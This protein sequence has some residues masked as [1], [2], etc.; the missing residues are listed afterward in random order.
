MIARDKNQITLI[1]SGNTSIGVQAYA[2]LEVS[3]KRHLAIDISKSKLG[4]TIWVEIAEA[5]GVKVGDLLDKKVIGMED[6]S[7][8]FG[9]H[10][11][12]KIIQK[13]DRVLEKPIVIMGDQ[14]VQ[15]KDP[16]DILE[17][18][19]VDSAGLNQSPMP[20]GSNDIQRTTEG[21]TFIDKKD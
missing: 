21:E 2:Y 1:Y 5:L 11:W 9:T 8:N 16:T 13:N 17:F 14:T 20:D 10:D 3:D 18:I 19:G 6:N 15:I 12:I 7:D 4:D